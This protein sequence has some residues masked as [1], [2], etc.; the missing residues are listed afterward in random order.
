MNKN[1]S[2][3]FAHS[4][5][6]YSKENHWTSPDILFDLCREYL[7]K[8][9][10]LLDI[11]IGTGLSAEPFKN[12][13]LTIYGL[14]NSEHM[15]DIC[16]SK[17]IADKLQIYDLNDLPLPYPGQKFDCI[18]ANGVFHLTGCIEAHFHEIKRLLKKNGIFAFTIDV[19]L[20][21]NSTEYTSTEISG[22]WLK[23]NTEHN[24]KTYKH[25]VFYIG[26]LTKTVNFSI[27]G[28]KDFCA[29]RSV[30]ENREVHF[31]VYISQKN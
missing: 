4:Y 12:A 7:N 14:D 21:E 6:S 19:F 27:L 30:T 22:E 20:S 28:F 5:D 8:D 11:G 10:I 29:F 9:Q 25:S 24:F 17:N 23:I 3:D 18:I 16:R 26:E 1:I 13:G 2:R 15:L 31:R